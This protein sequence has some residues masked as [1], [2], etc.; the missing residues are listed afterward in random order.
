MTATIRNAEELG[1]TPLRRDALAIAEAAY[2]A[3]DTHI[4]LQEAVRLE[5]DVLTVAG[6]TYT[7]P[8]GKGVWV[9]GA[10]K[11]S[12]IAAASLEEILG[13]RI[14]GGVIIDVA[15]T[16]HRLPLKNLEGFI[17]THP[18]PSEQNAAAAARLLEV[19]RPLGEDD[20]VIALVS[21]GGSTLLVHPE[22]PVTVATEVAVFEELTAAGASI[23]EMNTVRK[24]LSKARG[25]GVAAAAYPAQV[26]SLVFSDVPGN[27]LEF[28][29]SGPTVRDDTTVADAEAV[30]K[31]YHVQAL[32][33]MPLLETPKEEKYFARVHNELLV[34]NV[35]ALEAMKR[36]ARARGY[37][38]QIVTDRFS[39]KAHE[40]AAQVAAAL[41]AAAPG[42]AL[43]YGGESTVTL[44]IH[45]G[46]GGRN[47]ELALAGLA[48]IA[49]DELIL[50][51]SSDGHDNTDN[52]GALCDSMTK[53]HA[54]TY[55]LDTSDYLDAHRSY[56]FF[57]TTG[58]ALIT[59]YT[60][61][62]VSDLIIA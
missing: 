39:G 48:H 51:F 22:A 25:G 6:N 34:T 13:A 27:D 41:R 30:I 45:V 15:D 28:I 50:P 21:G 52:A 33:G 42:T 36:A 8:P 16:G 37:T 35:R 54:V 20:V 24:H 10:G 29:S 11:S 43:L 61:A 2:A 58:D 26:I 9:V 56:D 49:D 32:S 14:A 18:K 5:G 3:I 59:G 4:V 31:K 62:N 55:A 38:P 46:R 57:T 7:L 19:L 23:E 53:A 12:I 44:G 60:G 1:Q 47:Q 17:G 40:I